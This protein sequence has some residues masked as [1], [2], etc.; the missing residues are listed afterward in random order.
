M[1]SS[2]NAGDHDDGDRSAG[3][4]AARLGAVRD[5]LVAAQARYG[6]AP[7]SVRLIAVSKTK[8]PAAV[9]EAY[10]AGQRAFGENHLQDAM[11]KVA[12]LDLPDLEWHFIGAVQSNK[13]R[14]VAQHFDWVHTIDR[15]KTATRLSAQRPA[16]LAP[17]NVCIQV[18]VSG[19]ASK[20]GVTAAESAELAQRVAELARLKLRGLMAIPAPEEDFERQRLAFR[21]LAEQLEVLRGQ[22]LALDT[23][24][25]GMTHDM[26]AAVAEGATLVRIG[27]AIFGARTRLG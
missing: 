20:S 2:Y 23:L 6:R 9:R 21:V 1:N 27:T 18:N 16:G 22:G 17:L 3:T 5:Q 4:I 26:E 25:M 8:P 7:G 24:S 19:E 15:L 12:T 14:A 10:D 11:T 13:T